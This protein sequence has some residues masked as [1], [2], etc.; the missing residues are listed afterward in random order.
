MYNPTQTVDYA[1]ICRRMRLLH[2]CANMPGADRKALLNE[3][4]AVRKELGGSFYAEMPTE[5]STSEL[6]QRKSE[7][8]LIVSCIKCGRAFFDPESYGLM[9]DGVCYSCGR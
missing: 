3:R 4:D 8:F 9:N 2:K 7:P 1:G 6:I 5:R